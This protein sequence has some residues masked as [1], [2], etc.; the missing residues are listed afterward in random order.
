VTPH[1]RTEILAASLR[2]RKKEAGRWVRVYYSTDNFIALL[3]I[4]TTNRATKPKKKAW[5]SAEYLPPY[6]ISTPDLPRSRRRV[7]RPC[8]S[9]S[10]IEVPAR[11]RIISTPDV[12]RSRHVTP[13]ASTSVLASISSASE[14]P[15]PPTMMDVIDLVS[16]DRKLAKMDVQNS[17]EVLE[18]TD[19]ESEVE[20]VR[21]PHQRVYSFSP[22]F[23]VISD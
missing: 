12:P 7:T 11:A 3:G 9:T 5:V 20:I 14:S 22:E 19:S 23:I 1:T 2:E 13:C 4:S 18:I 10:V 17:G 6:V 16:Q 15:D 8:A 21:S